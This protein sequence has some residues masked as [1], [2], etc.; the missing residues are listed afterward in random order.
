M[1]LA[2][3]SL[4]LCRSAFLHLR[5]IAISLLSALFFQL[6]NPISVNPPRQLIILIALFWSLSRSSTFFSKQLGLPDT[7]FNMGLPIFKPQISNAVLKT[8]DALP[9][10]VFPLHFNRGH[11]LWGWNAENPAAAFLPCSYSLLWE[12]IDTI[13][14]VAVTG[15]RTGA[16]LR[17]WGGLQGNEHT[18]APGMHTGVLKFRMQQ[19]LSATPRQVYLIL[20]PRTH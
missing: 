10:L 11:T 13:Q 4:P 5:V 1:W 6:S 2:D 15:A 19:L 8:R 7:L 17:S 16:A 12:H 3:Y 20:L 18:E 14:L 9:A